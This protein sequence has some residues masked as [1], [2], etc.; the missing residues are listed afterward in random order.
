M[1]I[2]VLGSGG[3]EH[4]IVWKLKNDSRIEH[5]YCIPGNPGT[6]IHAKNVNIKL[7]DYN[8]ILNFV[9]NYD[10]DFTVVGPEGPLCDGIVDLFHKHNHT[11]FGPTKEAAL[12]ESSKIHARDLMKSNNIPHP[13]YFPCY[14]KYD[15]EYSKQQLGF[16]LVI[17]EDG[18]A[19]GKGVFICKNQTE[20][21]DVMSIYFRNPD[22]KCKLSVEECLQGPELSLFIIC[23]GINYII[24]NNA[25]DYKRAYDNNLGPNTGGM[26]AYSPSCYY[27]KTLEEKIRRRIIEPTLNSLLIRGIQ[28]CGFLYFGLML[29]NNEP[30]V[31]EYNVRLGDPETQVILP[32]M[33]TSLLD[34]MECAVFN[35]LNECNYQVNEGYCTTVVIS[36]D[37]YPGN[38][39]SGFPINQQGLLK[40]DIIFHSGT[41]VKKNKIL[42]SGGR[43]LSTVGIGNTINE[44][45]T[46]AYNLVSKIF[47]HK[48][49]YRTDIGNDSLLI[50]KQTE[51]IIYQGK[52][53]KVEQIGDDLLLLTASNRLTAFNRYICDIPNKGYVLNRL[54]EWWFTRT[55]HIICNH[56][57][58]SYNEHMIVRKTVPIKIEF[59]VRGFMTGS[60]NTSIWPMYKNGERN[61][62]G[63]QFREGYK[64]YDR[65]DNII[66]TPTTKEEEDA[67]ITKYEI[68]EKGYLTEKE[69]DYIENISIQLFEYGQK[70][71]LEKGIILVDTK[72]EFGR[73]D[74]DII[75]IDEL[76]TCDSSRYWLY[77]GV[78]DDEPF[79]LDKDVI[80]DWVN[81]KCN[82]YT[83]IIPTIP[84]ELIYE[85]KTVYQMY[86]D[87]FYE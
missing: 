69:Y 61:M 33:K 53:R 86:D 6:E 73:L 11:I 8:S 81:S 87:Y 16:P 44:S 79:K 78:V 65:L 30:Y 20:Y 15:V 60:T 28:Y 40:S 13:R 32:M 70:L 82:P 19:S 80:R 26:G 34:L 23:N 58:F 5:I 22:V 63:I 21:E 52:V 45:I 35:R 38:F 27:N 1:K 49:N 12:L 46:N 59:I 25:Q 83:D 50:N 66:V 48:M 67:P 17:K 56:F 36:S 75:L 2:L 84:E 74:N 29:V 47:F 77:S 37:G 3:R 68:I 18:L 24:L 42:T 85:M 72:Y 71:S 10:V 4:A 51:R 57:L 62:Y 55:K 64:K 9:V 41:V 7:T 76:H 54:S 43:V 14:T 31:I 39:K